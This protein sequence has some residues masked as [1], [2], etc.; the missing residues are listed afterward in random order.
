MTSRPRVWHDYKYFDLVEDVLKNGVR[1]TDRTGTGTLSV[2]SRQM[3]FPLHDGTIPLLTSK[4]MHTRS[5]IHEILWYLTGDTNTKYLK[6]N[7]VTIW[8]EWADEG[9][10]LGPVYGEQWR[11]W[12]DYTPTIYTDEEKAIASGH[13]VHTRG[14]GFYWTYEERLDQIA[15]VINTL[16]RDPNSRRLMVS[17]WNVADLNEM[18]LPPCH[19]A[20]QFWTRPI[21]GTRDMPKYEL[22]C[23]LNQRSCDVGLGVPFNI[24]QYSILTRMIAQAVGMAAGEFIWNGGDVHI[25]TNHIDALEE[26]IKRDP[27]P[28][29][30]LA[31]NL[32]VT[33]IDSFRFEDFT[34]VG[35]ESHPAIKMEV[36]V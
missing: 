11:R 34:V 33:D 21:V 22:S 16:K 6:D 29:P 10:H 27:Y 32:N 23:M 12:K 20:F 13:D 2:F 24:V 35:Y 28:S 1:K 3:R 7:N 15:H 14:N 4:K 8:D 17:A 31:L 5:I 25:Y 36:S 30:Q 26:Q 19:Y 9:G 18:A